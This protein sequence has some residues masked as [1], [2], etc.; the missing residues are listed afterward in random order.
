[1]NAALF[2]EHYYRCGCGTPYRR[3]ARWL[4]FF[5]GVAEQIVGRL[6]PPTV[7]DA[8]CAMGF[9]V[10][11]LRDRGVAAE[12]VDVSEYAL[13]QVRD[14]VKPYCR[15]ASV[16]DPFPRRY[17]LIVCL[18]VLEHLPPEAA[19]PAVANLCAFTDDVLFSSSPSDYSEPTHFNVQP[20][21]YWAELFARQG[22]IRDVDFDASFLTPWAVR[23]RRNA[24]ALPRVVRAYERRFAQLWKENT[25]LRAA[26]TRVRRELAETAAGPAWETAQALQRLRRSLAPTGSRRARWLDRLLRAGPVRR[27]PPPS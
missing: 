12:G 16:L 26:L 19:E 17:A 15:A 11:A 14:D 7:L 27:T 8:G 4:D 1:M 24:E 23:F 2:D 13:S 9:L 18:E 25:E 3:E 21:D 20:A 22:F 6:A 5:S 10:E